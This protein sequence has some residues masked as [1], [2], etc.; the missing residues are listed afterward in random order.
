MK[1]VWRQG[2]GIGI[3]SLVIGFFACNRDVERQR[4]LKVYGADWSEDGR[5]LV[6]GRFTDVR[7]TYGWL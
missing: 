7:V 1:K 4:I 5:V 2:V 6:L 3:L